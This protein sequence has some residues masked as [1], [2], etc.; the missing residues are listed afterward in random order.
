M[1][2]LVRGL[3]SWTTPELGLR[4][5]C[6]NETTTLGRQLLRLGDGNDRLQG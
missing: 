4:E 6:G 1:I 5:R 2:T 3:G